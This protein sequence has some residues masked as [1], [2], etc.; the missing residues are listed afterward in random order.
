MGHGDLT[1][2]TQYLVTYL[3]TQPRI[4]RHKI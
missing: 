3:I 1:L 2:R 4:N